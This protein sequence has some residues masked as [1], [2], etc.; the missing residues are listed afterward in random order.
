MSVCLALAVIYSFGYPG[1]APLT[2]GAG[3]TGTVLAQGTGSFSDAIGPAT[4]F[5]GEQQLAAP[6]AASAFGT[7]DSLV[8]GSVIPDSVAPGAQESSR[9]TADADKA[10]VESLSTMERP[11]KGM[12]ISP[13]Q[14]LTPSS[15]F[16][17]RT[18]PITGEHGEFHSGQD[19]AAPCGTRVFSADAGVVRAAGWHPWGGGNRVELDHGNGLVTTYNHL[20]GIGV[21]AGDRVGAGQVIA[22][23]GT[24]GWSTGCHLHFETIRNGAHTDPGEWKLIPLEGSGPVEMPSLVNFTPGT[25][26]G[27]DDD[28]PWVAY[29]ASAE[30]IHPVAFK[31]PARVDAEVAAQGP[32]S[33]G[34]PS[35]SAKYSGT[36]KT[37]ESSDTP[38]TSVASTPSTKPTKPSDPTTPPS[39]T[40]PATPGPTSPPSTEPGT[41]TP[42]EPAP[43]EPAP[44]DPAPTEPAPTPTPP[45]P[46][47]PAPTE[48][49]PTDPAPAP[50]EPAPT[51]PAPTDPAPT[52][53]APSEPAPTEPAPPEPVPTVPPTVSVTDPLAACDP[54][55]NPEAIVL[56]PATGLP[57]LHPTT[58]EPITAAEFCALAAV[59]P[60]PEITSTEAAGEAGPVPTTGP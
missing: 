55:I 24:T 52:D 16:G 4:G 33:S 40:K 1:S 57:R 29:L 35:L 31:S 18:S 12:L 5:V 6:E 21:K 41:P 54:A 53:P 26:N 51:E 30:P 36:K 48:P 3:V 38:S 7:T 45:A 19:F 11:G 59:S 25:G 15:P 23:V 58:G 13:L 37:T 20:E 28:T 50:T 14:F 22:T 56:D 39:T 42:T 2:S 27:N 8:P 32:R 49:A 43:T 47:D 10:S 60:T 44:T 46:T 34:K 17:L 9:A